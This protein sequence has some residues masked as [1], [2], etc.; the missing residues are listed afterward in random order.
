MLLLLAGIAGTA[1]FTVAAYTR[2][3][4]HSPETAV[5]A[6]RAVRELAAVV[7]VCTRAVEAILDV[8]QGHPRPSTYAATPSRWRDDDPYDPDETYE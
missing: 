3:R 2:L 8:L 4:T 5:A 7:L 1:A 6:A